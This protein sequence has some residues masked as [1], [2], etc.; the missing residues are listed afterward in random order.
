MSKLKNTYCVRERQGQER[1]AA[2]TN[3]ERE[4]QGAIEPEKDN[5]CDFSVIE[6][7]KDKKTRYCNLQDNRVMNCQS[8]NG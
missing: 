7:Q 8:G 4:R 6:K 2:R 1:D 3:R 5:E